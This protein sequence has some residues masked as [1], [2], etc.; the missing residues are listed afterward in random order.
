[1]A[2]ATRILVQRGDFDIAAEVARLKALDR[3]AGA[4]VTF[5]GVCRGE[6]GTL[7][8][9]ELEHYPGMAEAE[10]ER[11]ASEAAGRWPLSGIT[12]IHRFGRM[13]PGDN[14]VLVAT[15]STHRQAAFEAA[16]FLM[17]FMKVSAPFWKK[18]HRP[19]D[20]PEWVAPN[21]ADDAAQDRWRK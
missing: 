18:Q 21:G 16:S 12:V 17:D 7:A 19:G 4:I 2:A 15:A 20:K 9:L 10:I 5:T 3:D 1:V 8:A 13:A 14:I 11:I 6:H